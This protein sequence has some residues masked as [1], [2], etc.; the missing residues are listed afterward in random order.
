MAQGKESTYQCERLKKCGFVPWVGK[1]PGVGNGSPLQY[2]CLVNSMDRGAWQATVHGVLMNQIQ[3][4]PLTLM[5]IGV[6]FKL[7][8]SFF[9]WCLPR[10]GIAGSYGSSIFSFLRNLHT[11]F[12]SGCTNLYPHQR[13]T[14]VPFSSHPSQ[15][16]LFVVFLTIATLTGVRW[17]CCGFNLCYSDN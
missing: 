17:Y 12:D 4:S 16:L 11:V 14:W 7:V 5:N 13:C 10:S 6:I 2:S 9:I 3:L 1:I 8:F 15:H